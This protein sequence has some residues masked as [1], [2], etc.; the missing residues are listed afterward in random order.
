MRN[1]AVLVAALCAASPLLLAQESAEKRDPPGAARHELPNPKHAEHEALKE[2]VGT[3]YCKMVMPAMPGIPGMEKPTECEAT[4]TGELLANGLWLK[5]RSEGTMGGQ[6]SQC[7][8]LV[9]YDPF[10][11]KYTSFCIS[12]HESR[13]SELDGSYDAKAKAWSWSGQSEQGAISSAITWKDA[14]TMV[15]VV[16]MTPPGASE[17]QT[18]TITRQRSKAAAA[19]AARGN[20]TGHDASQAGP[21]AEHKEL[22][23]TVGDWDAVLKTAIDPTQPPT[24]AKG[25]ERVSA[26]C[27]GR[28]T[29]SDFHGTMMGQPFEGHAVIGYD[30]AAK[31]Y[32]SYCFDSTSPTWARTTGKIDGTSRALS[33]QG[34]CLCPLGTPMTMKE[35]LTWKDADTRHVNVEFSGKMGTQ[36]M[37]LTFV[38]KSGKAE[39]AKK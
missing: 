7:L 8:W 5:W 16:R 31:Q 37:E 30:E 20:A 38:R 2:F 6:P 1:H 18:M 19:S 24:E 12:N 13:P 26:I 36:K 21:T 27:G 14:D 33:L 4:E 22:L 15:E 9:G 25:T 35:V 28:Y 34:Q 17:P 23:R 29:W 39:K 32:V 3:W 10:A 11:K